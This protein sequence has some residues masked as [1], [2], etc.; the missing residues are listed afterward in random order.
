MVFWNSARSA[1]QPAPNHATPT[2]NCSLVSGLRFG[3]PKTRPPPRAVKS[4][5]SSVA[6]GARKPVE[7]LARTTS[8]SAARKATPADQVV[9][10]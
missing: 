10:S 5:A 4:A 2:S 6:V 1:R 8:R 3:L 7:A 9:A